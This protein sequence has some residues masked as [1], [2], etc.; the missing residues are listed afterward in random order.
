MILTT[1]NF[2]SENL[3]LRSQMNVILPQ[4]TVADARSGQPVRYKVLYLLHGL[5]DDHTAWQRWTS[6]ECYVEGLDLIVV[7]PAVARSFYTDMS[8][9]AK[10]WTFVSEE[11]PLVVRDLF[12]VSEKREDT[13]VA[14]LSMGGYGAF[15]LALSHPHRFAAAASFS[16]ALDV[17]SMLSN[18]DPVWQ[19]EMRH[20]FGDLERVA[21][22]PRD[23][24]TL[25]VAGAK[26]GI[27]PRLFQY[28]GKADMLYA[29]NIRFR[30]FIKP[31]GYDFHWE[32]DGGDHTWP[33]WDAMVQKALGWFFKK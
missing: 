25:A 29:D 4:R 28:C 24:F 26:A 23:L 20:I 19:T 12:P 7:M 22:G 17:R 10:Y 32:E 9:G 33:Y 6:I 13:F 5:S 2:L 15:K 30:D 8:C 18:P 11:L 21:G 14:G 16:G 27:R 1:V 31:F 3:G